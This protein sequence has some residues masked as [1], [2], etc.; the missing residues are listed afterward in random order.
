MAISIERACE[1]AAKHVSSKHW[2]GTFA[3]IRDLGNKWVF[4]P[5][6]PPRCTPRGG[7]SP[8]V[9]KNLGIPLTV[10]TVRNLDR[11]RNAPLVDV[12][13]KWRAKD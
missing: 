10:V 2:D 12:P 8:G 7:G 13:E 11:I 4:C 9:T 1:I 5:N 3:A 6:Y